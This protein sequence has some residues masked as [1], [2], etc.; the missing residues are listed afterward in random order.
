MVV[1]HDRHELLAVASGEGDDTSGRNGPAVAVCR[2]CPRSSVLVNCIRRTVHGASVYCTPIAEHC[3]LLD[4]Y[5]CFRIS[6]T[7]HHVASHKNV[8]QRKS[9]NVVS[10][11]VACS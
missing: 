9:L 6:S 1:R 4:E 3:S 5:R 8:A 11:V 7:A 10:E 2:V